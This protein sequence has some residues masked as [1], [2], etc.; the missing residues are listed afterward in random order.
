MTTPGP[1]LRDTDQH[2][3]ERVIARADIDTESTPKGIANELLF[4]A[5]CAS[6]IMPP[7]IPL[8]CTICSPCGAEE[9]VR[10]SSHSSSFYL[11]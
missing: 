2:N 5:I 3:G 4:G 8:I 10:F 7:C 9:R 6:I 1:L 11:R